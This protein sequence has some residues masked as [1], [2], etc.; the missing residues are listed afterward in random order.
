MTHHRALPS[1]AGAAAL[2]VLGACQDLTVPNNNNPDRNRALSQPGDVETLIASTWRP[3]WNN[4]QGS[5]YPSTVLSTVAD[6]MTTTAAN[7]GAWNFSSE[8]RIP[9][10]NNPAAAFPGVSQTPYYA[11][12]A[13]LSNIHDALEQ[14][15]KGMKIV[16]A[17]GKDNTIRARAYAKMNQGITHG[18]VGLL[19][20]QGF[21]VTEKTDIS[22][23]S[24]LS[25]LPLVSYKVLRDTAI[26]E[27][28][29][30]IDLARKNTFQIDG[31]I[32][33]LTMSNADLAR[34][35]HSWIARLVA[36]TPRTPAERQAAD[37]K[38]AIAS[39]DS[40]ITSDWGPIGGPNVLTSNYKSYTQ[41]DYTA[42]RIIYYADNRL[43]GPAD[44]SGNY[45]KWVATPM[46]QRQR[47][48]IT[49][50]DRRV[51][52]AGGSKT[53]GKYFRYLSGSVSQ[54]ADRGT[55]HHSYYQLYRWPGSGGGYYGQ[56]T[57]GQLVA[58][59]RAELDL[60]KAEG[61][62]RTG[63]AAGAV[64]LINKSRVANGSLPPATVNG[65]SGNDCVPKTDAGACGSL[66]D[67]LVYEKRI[68]TAGTDEMAFYD[69]RGFG[70]LTKGTW[71][72]LPIPGRELSVLGLANYTFGGIG[73]P[74]SA[75]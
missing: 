56:I 55:Y 11:L 73:G 35:A 10:D 6:E 72:Q 18:I 53:N 28:R 47:F 63:D 32:P 68:E 52:G 60:L 4:T 7:F 3:V 8:P 64:T 43:L 67:V 5:D 2:L 44:I 15:D 41:F 9:F 21:I 58:I 12:Y 54:R 46:E 57:S 36:Y 74:S 50:P 62:L 49:T 16:D 31:W 70:L 23:P 42:T 29:A 66:M 48:E 37:W 22:D 34:L 69:A 14:I 45:Q 71:L 39:A 13:N 33:G 40:G 19:Y 75:P 27:L 51:T 26:G 20:D 65:V 24:T 59:S 25:K 17:S 61:L 1:V 38:T 30:A